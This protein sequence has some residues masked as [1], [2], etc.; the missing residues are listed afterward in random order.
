M[1]GSKSS[2]L[3]LAVVLLA[4]AVFAGCGT[5]SNEGEAST[6]GARIA[7]TGEELPCDATAGCAQGTECYDVSQLTSQ[8]NHLLCLTEPCASVSCNV[9]RCA[10]DDIFPQAVVCVDD[11]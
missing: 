11:G 5:E 7:L 8:P 9:G 6:K 10:I 2:S 1:M 4:L 3:S